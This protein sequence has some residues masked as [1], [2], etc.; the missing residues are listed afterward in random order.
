MGLYHCSE[1]RGCSSSVQDLSSLPGGRPNNG[2]VH[3]GGI[4]ASNHLYCKLKKC[5][6]YCREPVTTYDMLGAAAVLGFANFYRRFIKSFS[7]TIRPLKD[8]LRGK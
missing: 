4:G 7:T 5:E 8:L 6:F 2:A 1:G 3:Q